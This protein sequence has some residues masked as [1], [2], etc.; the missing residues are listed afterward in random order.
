MTEDYLHHL[1][2]FQ[3]FDRQDLR[4][5]S[6]E[7]I[8]VHHPGYLNRNS[9]PDFSHARLSL[10]GQLWAGSVEIH[11]QDRD[12]YQHG[13][14]H[15]PLYQNVVLHVVYEHK[16]LV[17]RNNGQAI[18]TLCLK[19]RIDEAS[20]WRYERFLQNDK[21]LACARLF[22]QV[23]SFKIH[24]M[25]DR[26]L[27]ER[28]AQRSDR[29]SEI[30]AATG[31][32]WHECFHRW[33]FYGFGLKVN[34]EAMLSL[35]ERLPWRYLNKLGNSLQSLEALLLGTAGLLEA[36][37]TD[38]QIAKW[39]REFTFLQQKWSLQSMAPANWRY[40]KLRPQG[41][42]DRRL[43]QLA[44]LYSNEINLFALLLARAPEKIEAAFNFRASA[45]WHEHFRL[46]KRSAKAST[47]VS[48]GFYQ[49][50][51][52]NVLLPFLFFYG[53]QRREQRYKN[54]AMEWLQNLPAENHRYSRIMSKVGFNN[55]HAA[56]SQALYHL[57]HHY[58]KPKKC[59][60]CDIGIQLLKNENVG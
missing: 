48:P 3:A 60:N 31:Q 45:Y 7:V 13:H 9:G 50:L 42:P 32:D 14:Q 53:H 17:L 57:Y 8:E 20:Y 26:C 34:A 56:D 55:G 23:D 40:A 35:A 37:E 51:L 25:L 59:L 12:W 46:G 5:V 27:V 33:L 29:L 43:G 38:S 24:H 39:R 58:C 18:P 44:A 19:P 4:T 16:R 52:V 30:F 28:F 1:W 11:L 6:G 10:N 2:K 21:D 41:F 47:H 22:D 15:D 36:A 49:K 54:L